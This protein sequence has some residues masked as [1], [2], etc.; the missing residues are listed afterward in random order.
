[1]SG[2]PSHNCYIG[3]PCKW[4][5]PRPAARRLVTAAEW[6]A[7]QEKE[8]VAAA[9]AAYE[10]AMAAHRAAL[11]M[12]AHRLGLPDEPVTEQSICH[13]MAECRAADHDPKLDAGRGFLQYVEALRK[14]RD[15]LLPL[16]EAVKLLQSSLRHAR[17]ELAARAGEEK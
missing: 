5:T 17:A 8:K 14:E 9:D 10:N 16:R 2:I 15:E 6:L 4:S 7:K 13:A 3:C 1:M 12:V 11:Q